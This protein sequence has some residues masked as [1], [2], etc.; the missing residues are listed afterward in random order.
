MVFRSL[1]AMFTRISFP[2]RRFVFWPAWNS[3][4]RKKNIHKSKKRGEN[5]WRDFLSVFLG[6]CFFLLRDFRFFS[7]PNRTH[8]DLHIAAVCFLDAACWCGY[9]PQQFNAQLRGWEDP[10]NLWMKIP[11][12]CW[13]P[14]GSNNKLREQSNNV[15]KLGPKKKRRRW[16]VVIEVFSCFW[17]YT[18]GFAVYMILVCV[19]FCLFCLSFKVPKEC[20][21]IV[22]LTEQCGVG[23]PNWRWL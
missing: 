7:V 4:T 22:W 14:R 19:L 15:Q 12:S 3:N 21:P 1:V 5:F 10:R 18:P 20:K 11:Q 8:D 6:F 13:G 2:N 9:V 23:L 16:S 17:R